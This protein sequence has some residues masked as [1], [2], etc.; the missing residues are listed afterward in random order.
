[1]SLEVKTVHRQAFKEIFNLEA[2][3][4][5]I[6]KKVLEKLFQTIDYKVS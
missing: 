5:K 4:G 2:K 6:D 1:M 3:D